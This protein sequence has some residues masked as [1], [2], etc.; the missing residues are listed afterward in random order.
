MR[1]PWPWTWRIEPATSTRRTRRRSGADMP[2][3]KAFFDLAISKWSANDY[4]N[5]PIPALHQYG[6][7]LLQHQRIKEA[8]HH[9]EKAYQI[10]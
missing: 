9:L 3:A 1:T 7:F 5:T 2:T 10:W 8:N 6:H 4:V